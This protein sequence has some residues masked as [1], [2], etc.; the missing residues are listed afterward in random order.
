MVS[1]SVLGSHATIHGYKAMVHSVKG[2]DRMIVRYKCECTGAAYSGIMTVPSK[3][4]HLVV[5]DLGSCTEKMEK[6]RR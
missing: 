4:S 3:T 2:M 5:K 6:A 1:L